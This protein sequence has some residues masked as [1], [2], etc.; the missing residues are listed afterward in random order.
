M[1][2]ESFDWLGPKVATICGAAA[3]SVGTALAMAGELA[4]QLLGVPLPVV[5]GAAAGAGIARSLMDPVGFV[6]ALLV[7]GAWTIAGCVGAPLAQAGLG[8]AGLELALTPNVLAGLAALVA[9]SPF[10]VPR[11]WPF[12]QAWLTKKTGGGA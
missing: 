8:K 3:G 5:M 2:L 10:W 4:T 9:A 1:R 11:V 7:T 6:R 12:A